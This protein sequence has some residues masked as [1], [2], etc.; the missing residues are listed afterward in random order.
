MIELTN[1]SDLPNAPAVYA[2]FG[3]SGRLRYVAYV[4]LGSKLRGRVEPHLVRRDS[5]VTT[6]VSAV[7][8]NPDFVTEVQWWEHP[9]F[10]R[11]DALEAA[12]LVGLD[13][14]EPALRSRGGITDRAKQ[15]YQDRTFR[16]EMTALFSGKATGR[17]PI[18]SLNQAW[19]QIDELKD[20]IRRIEEHIDNLR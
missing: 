19:E 14:L 9:K 12:E 8:L 2:M 20:R 1:I 4:G 18:R 10:G 11:Q 7:S 3:G 16:E 17:L 6:G 5:S 15:L 13:V